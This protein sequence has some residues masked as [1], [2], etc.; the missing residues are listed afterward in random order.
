MPCGAIG[1]RPFEALPV[2]RPSTACCRAW[3]RPIPADAGNFS[4]IDARVVR[5]IGPRRARS[6]L[7]RPGSWVGFKQRGIE[8]RRE[9]RYDGR[10]RVALAR[11]VAAGQDRHLFLLVVPAHCLLRHRLQLA[12]PVCCWVAMPCFARPSPI[13]E[14]AGLDLRTCWSPVSLGGQLAGHLHSRRIRDPHLRSGPRPPAVCRRTNPQ[15]ASAADNLGPTTKRCLAGCRPADRRRRRGGQRA[16]EFRRPGN[17]DRPGRRPRPI[18]RMPAPISGPKIF[19][20]SRPNST[21]PAIWSGDDWRTNL[22]TDEDY[23]D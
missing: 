21:P 20:P 4:I 10:P 2:P 5:E 9:R 11:F 16:A 7:A 18:G 6:L 14:R 3:R 22:E 1:P 15:P 8:V 19:W 17:T 23:E 13:V 12:G